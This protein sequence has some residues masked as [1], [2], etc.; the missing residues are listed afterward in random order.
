[1][2][3]LDHKTYL[4]FLDIYYLELYQIYRTK[5]NYFDNLKNMHFF[6]KPTVDIT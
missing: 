5:V 1:M 4:P 3:S 6:H 2:I